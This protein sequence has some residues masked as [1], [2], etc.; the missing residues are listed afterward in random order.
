MTSSACVLVSGGVESA[1]LLSDALHRYDRVT[2]LYIRNGLRWENAELF[3]LKKLIRSFR[4][5]GMAPLEILELPM[6]DVYGKH[7]STTG[8][9]VPGFTSPD[10]AVYLPG[11]NVL[12]LAKSACFAALGGATVIEI[13]VLK[14]NPFADSAKSFFKKMSGALSQA[15]SQPIQILAPLQKFNKSEIILKGRQLPLWLTFSCINPKR[16]L[17]CGRCNKCAERKRAFLGAGVED[18]TKYKR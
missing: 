12:F 18:K 1:V 9:S 10:E 7:W 17:H 13:G 8:S 3:H 4:S 14:H 15:L 5:P 2:P 16:Y 6:S 11:R